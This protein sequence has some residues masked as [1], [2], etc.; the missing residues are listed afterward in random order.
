MSNDARQSAC[1]HWIVKWDG[2]SNGRALGSLLHDAV[3]PARTDRKP[4]CSRIR[5]I[6]A[7]DRDRSLPNRHL[8][9]RHKHIAVIPPRH[10]GWVCGLEEQRQCFDE[11]G[12]GLT[13]D[14][15]WLA[16]SS[17]G[18]NDTNPSSSRSIMAVRRCVRCM[19]RVYTLPPGRVV[20]VSDFGRVY[21]GSC[22]TLSLPS[23]RDLGIFQGPRQ[24]GR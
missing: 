22:S 12:P 11:V 6:S 4:C 17:S 14:A 24:A 13:I 1:S 7:P 5:Q 21:L 10:L 20:A 8:N 23:R 18:H 2:N 9:L 19:I 3:A 16:I 15:P